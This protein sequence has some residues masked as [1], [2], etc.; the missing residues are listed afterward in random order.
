M[1]MS[2]ELLIMRHGE[3]GWQQGE[4][5]FSRTL[6]EWGRRE[7]RH[8]GKRLMSGRL[9]PDR[10]ISSPARRAVST[11]EKVCEGMGQPGRRFESD[12][13]I[14]EAGIKQLL[15]VLADCPADCGRL[16]LVGHN[17]GLEHLL[18]RLV[19]EDVLLAQGVAMSPGTLV[20][21]EMPDTW[22][23]LSGDA[24]LLSVMRPQS[25]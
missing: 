19:G 22:Q 18:V 8:I 17:P 12:E 1:A 10:I 13:R 20:R 14:Y 24:T 3:S 23:P 6:T 15:A 9:L 21:L 4:E 2:N 5:D 16:L 25:G 7:T 11:T